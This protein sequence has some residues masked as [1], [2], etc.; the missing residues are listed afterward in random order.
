MNKHQDEQDLKM[1]SAPGD[2]IYATERTKCKSTVFVA[3]LNKFGSEQGFDKILSTIQH[4]QSGMDLV[5]FLV[6]ALGNC[7]ESYH[8]SFLDK[9]CEPLKDAV[10][11]KIL[12]ADEKQLRAMMR[13]RTDEIVKTLWEKLMARLMSYFDSQV[14]KQIFNMNIGVLYLR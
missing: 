3:M 9:Y 8:K 11:N 2:V 6:V 4:E 10:Q 5:Y 7:A 12:N 1:L 14:H 13:E